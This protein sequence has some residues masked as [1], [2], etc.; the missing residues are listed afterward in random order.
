[1][2]EGQSALRNPTGPCGSELLISG[3][4]K[5][6]VLLVAPKRKYYEDLPEWG[7]I[8]SVASEIEL[9]KLLGSKVIAVAI[10]TEH[11]TLEEALAY[12]K[13]YEA[14]LQIPVLLPLQQGVSALVPELKKLLM[15]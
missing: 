3:N 1:L 7:E 15:L 12:Q 11:C 14:E 6:T 8:P 4:A 9:I 2:L 5:H 10:N 13:Q